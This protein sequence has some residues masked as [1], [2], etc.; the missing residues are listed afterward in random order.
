MKQYISFVA[1]LATVIGVP[2]ILLYGFRIIGLEIK[3]DRQ[4]FDRVAEKT[5]HEAYSNVSQFQKENSAEV[6]P[7][8]IELKKTYVAEFDN[9]PQQRR[10]LQ[11]SGDR[12]LW[13]HH[14]RR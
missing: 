9:R 5:W 1:E 8:E 4:A 14:D 2:M 6:R 7:K 3:S 10:K 11:A 12:T 13:R